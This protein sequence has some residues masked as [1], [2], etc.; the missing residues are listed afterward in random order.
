MTP[1]QL[2]GKSCCWGEGGGAALIVVH[3]A[4]DVS[5]PIR[6]QL[7][8]FRVVYQLLDSFHVNLYLGHGIFSLSKHADDDDDV[9]DNNNDEN[10]LVISE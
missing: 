9:E 5:E 10:D 7:A 3:F 8:Y 2:S 1:T 6:I 4:R